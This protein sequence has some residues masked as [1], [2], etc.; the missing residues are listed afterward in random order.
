MNDQVGDGGI[1]FE[2]EECLIV[3]RKKT[4]AGIYLGN[5]GYLAEF[6]EENQAN[7]HRS[8]IK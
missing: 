3:N 7:F 2:I 4:Q 1:N 8:C 5:V 6:L